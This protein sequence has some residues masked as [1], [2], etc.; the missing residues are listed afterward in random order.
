[1]NA[2]TPI[3]LSQPEYEA[4]IA[5]VAHVR[6]SINEGAPVDRLTVKA[7][8]KWDA[9]HKAALIE[10]SCPTCRRVATEGGL[11]P[12]HDGSPRCQSGSIASGGDYAHCSC[13]T[14]F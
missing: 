8:E 2:S 4:L 5:I 10:A 1:M 12:S 9:V 7:L 13:G 14:C 11:A 3:R 6:C